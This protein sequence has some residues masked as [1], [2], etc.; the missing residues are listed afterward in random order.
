[1]SSWH[2]DAYGVGLIRNASVADIDIVTTGR[3]IAAAGC[4]AKKRR[5]TIGR[6][7]VAGSVE[8]ERSITSGHVLTARCVGQK[9]NTAE[10]SSGGPFI[11]RAPWRVYCDLIWRWRPSAQA[12]YE[13]HRE[14]ARLR[15]PK[16][17]ISKRSF[18]F[19]KMIDL[20]QENAIFSH[21]VASSRLRSNN[22]VIL[23]QIL[24]Q[25]E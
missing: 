15:I 1:M 6:V 21:L 25:H 8:K 14:R 11:A 4:V 9:S 22:V 7:V 18:S 23:A 2:A 12:R 10:R 19:Q 20:R 13:C 5:C 24:V 16:S 3:E 17:S